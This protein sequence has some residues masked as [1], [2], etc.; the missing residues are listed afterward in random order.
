[1]AWVGPDQSRELLYQ[2]NFSFGL[3]SHLK[4]SEKLRRREPEETMVFFCPLGEGFLGLGK[5][6]GGP[7]LRSF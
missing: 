1:M 5:D 7:R 3:G 6:G 2:N 4:E